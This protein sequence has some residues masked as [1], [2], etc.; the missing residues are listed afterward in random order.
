MA[1]VL[2][3]FDSPVSD[4]AGRAYTARACGRAGDDGL[5]DG[6]IEFTPR[7]GGTTLRTERETTQPNR[8]D[9]EYW[10]SGLT[11]AYLQGA[12]ERAL[13]PLPAP[14]KPRA[15]EPVY[16]GPR[17]V[18]ISSATPPPPRDFPP[19]A[20]LDPFA[21]YTQG[22]DVLR[23]ELAALDDGHL[24]NIIRAHALAEVT[25]GEL[26]QISRPVLMDLI[27]SGVRRRR[28]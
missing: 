24:R 18:G 12:L 6:W 7:G 14:A 4:Q 2:L 3:Q 11:E 5:W 20:V 13:E 28:P 23:E 15:V 19:R 21:V 27:V 22:E 8:P 9:L 16:E 25:P 1:E 17:P 10:A 26:A